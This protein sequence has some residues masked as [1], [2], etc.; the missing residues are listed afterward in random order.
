MT[1]EIPTIEVLG[2][3][4]FD[5]DIPKLFEI[6]GENIISKNKLNRQI[7]L[8]DANVLVSSKKNHPLLNILSNETYLNLPDGMP[9]VWVGK[10]KGAKNID[11]CYGPDVFKFFIEN[12]VDKGFKHYFTGG[13]EGVAI[14]LRKYCKDVLGNDNIVG[15][16]SP[17]FS[18][19]SDQ[20]IQKIASDINKSNAD[21]VW[22][23]ISS[24]K[25]DIYAHRLSKRLNVHFIFTI[26][27]AFDF[28]TG[29]IT[30]APK[31]IQ[32]SG[33]EW[34]FRLVIEPRRLWK[35]YFTVIP[36]FVY[37]NLVDLLNRK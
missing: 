24:P 1:K 18:K 19:M 13:K 30:Q 9:G 4:I 12:S 17:P 5:G 16:H 34:L 37:Y 11:R 3:P 7:S 20:D 28:Y 22:I 2:I 26:G 27:A 29:N 8:C 6:T 23:G 15:V 10:L 25:Q 33:F 32:R 31:F 14:Q 35:R 21:I 36:L